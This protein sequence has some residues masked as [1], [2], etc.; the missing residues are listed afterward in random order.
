MMTGNEPVNTREDESDSSLLEEARKRADRGYTAFKDNITAAKDDVEFL[1]GNQWPESV[2]KERD[3]QGRPYLTLN[4]LPQFVDQIIGD[5]RQNRPGIHIHPIEGDNGQSEKKLSNQAGT[6]D[7]KLSE[8]YEA[9]IRNIEYTSNAEAHYDRSFQ[10][11]VEGGFG[12]LRV[13]TEYSDDTSFEQDIKIKSIKD[14]FAVIMDPDAEELDGSDASWCFVSQKMSMKEFRK[15][16]PKAR[17]GDLST[18]E[19]AEY[20]WWYE[21]D[22]VRVAEYFRREPATRTLLLMNTGDTYFLDEVEDV[23]D[24]LAKDQIVPIRKREVETYKVKW[25]KITS[26][27]VLEKEVDWPGRTI[28][29]VPVYG[30]EIDIGDK[31][32]YRGAIRYAHDAQR[33]HNYWMTAAT[34]RVALSPKA[35]YVAPAEA[36][37][38]FEPE[39]EN[40]NTGNSAV[41]RYNPI[42]GVDRP[43]REQP[44]SMPAAE[45]NMA[46][47]MTDEM[48]STVGIYDASIGAQGNETS[49]RA[50]IARQRQGDRGTFAYVDNLSRAIR[51]I[52][53]ILVELIPYIYDTERLIRLRFEDGSGDWVPINKT[54]IDDQSGKEIMLHDISAGKFDVTVTSG[55][56]YQTLRMEAADSLMQF[57]QA[58][59]SSANLVMDLVAQNM[60]WPGAQEIAKRLKKTLPPGILDQEEA[61]ELGIQP[62]QPTPEQQADMAKAE[63]D[64]AKAEADKVKAQA[65]TQKAEA[66]VAQAQADLAEA[67]QQMQRMRMEAQAAGAG[68]LQEMVYELVAE[69]V[70]QMVQNGQM[71]QPTQQQ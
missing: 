26:H 8:V 40:A 66:D 6:K 35:P 54:V 45:V 19:M 56:S 57:V 20:S 16:Y 67:Q 33:M 63:A 18:A 65:D 7:Y 22:Y 13:I 42:P 34:E 29:V 1:A 28:P 4:K 17:T 69:A 52:G 27:D 59:P 5:Q 14:R 37:E 68:S 70:A 53:K 38:G 41:L 25:M 48:K 3:D 44:A 9:V 50:I 61:D 12:W 43:Q 58:V 71:Q 21:E 64:I 2:K 49:G 31:T 46:L 23:L 10:H 60:D 51:R 15:R 62:P 24:E 55:P 47:T 39:W 32:F 36:I 30:K 11:S